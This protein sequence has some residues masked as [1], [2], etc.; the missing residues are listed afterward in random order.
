MQ[1]RLL[2][3]IVRAARRKRGF[4]SG[5][6]Y[7]ERLF[8]QDKGEGRFTGVGGLWRR[9]RVDIECSHTVAVLGERLLE[10][11]EG[12]VELPGTGEVLLGLEHGSDL[13]QVIV[14][15]GGVGG[16]LFG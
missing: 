1:R 7:V 4:G 12:V 13:E 10:G 6:W 11:G 15:E 3:R 2:R 14:C 16:V 8:V 9:D 5:G